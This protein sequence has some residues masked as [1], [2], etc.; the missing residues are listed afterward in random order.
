MQ[1]HI[2]Q[3]NL[4]LETDTFG[5]IHDIAP[6]AAR[7]LGL[8]ARGARDRDVRLFFPSSFAALSQLLRDAGY[9]TV[10]GVHDLH[11]RDRKR[12]RMRLRMAA[13]SD[14]VSCRRVRCT[15]EPL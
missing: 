7:L 10:E 6:E 8:S 15:L 12:M 9:S 4:W 2:E 11:P 1:S 14:D 13:C 5:L 3:T